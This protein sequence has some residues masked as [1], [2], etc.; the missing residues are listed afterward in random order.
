LASNAILPTS[1]EKEFRMTVDW[2]MVSA[3]AAVIAALA[4]IILV[5]A[6]SRSTRLVAGID[7]LMRQEHD[8]HRETSMLERRRA[9]AAA[10]LDGHVV[11]ELDDVLDFFEGLGCYL[12]KGV[13][14]RDMVWSSFCVSSTGWW[15]AA[16][17]YIAQ[18]R[19]VDRS[20][21]S[22]YAY[23]VDEM[24]KVERRERGG[25]FRGVVMS[26]DQ[27]R[28][29]LENELPSNDGGKVLAPLPQPR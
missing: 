27:I 25:A 3:L 2:S 10:L 20:I 11:S 1:P 14:D 26:E 29:F 18:E 13:L 22:F 5:V 7:V 24:N 16:S 6:E 9:A 23:L 28:R 21:Y 4:A 17:S 15:F 19:R 8:Y 12:R